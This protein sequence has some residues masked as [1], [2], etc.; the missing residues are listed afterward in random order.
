MWCIQILKYKTSFVFQTNRTKKKCELI[1][2]S[3]LGCLRQYFFFILCEIVN[4]T[5]FMLYFPIWGTKI[6]TWNCVCCYNNSNSDIH[7][8]SNNSR[9]KK[10]FL[11]WLLLSFC[12]FQLTIC[13][14]L[15]LIM[16]AQSEPEAPFFLIMCYFYTPKRNMKHGTRKYERK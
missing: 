15:W 6:K 9:E 3:T 13:K 14:L 1:L 8:H 12:W 7:S 11:L 2:S 10:F 4:I 16:I 5:I